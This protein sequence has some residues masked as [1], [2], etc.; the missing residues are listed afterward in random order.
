MLINDFKD[1]FK[2]RESQLIEGERRQNLLIVAVLFF[3]TFFAIAYSLK[4]L[5][6]LKE[7][8]DNPFTN[9]VDLPVMTN[10][11]EDTYSM[12]AGF[13]DSRQLQDSF[14]LS[15]VSAYSKFY[16]RFATAEPE[17]SKEFFGRSVAFDDELL[18]RIVSTDNNV[19]LLVP[20][21]EWNNCGIVVTYRLLES[22]GFDVLD[23]DMKVMIEQS[24]R[25]GLGQSDTSTAAVHNETARF[26]L[27]VYAVVNDLPNYA[28]YVVSP[29]MDNCLRLAYHTTGFINLGDN[30]MN[31]IVGSNVSE[32][33]IQS[34]IGD[35]LFGGIKEVEDKVDRAKGKHLKV[36]LNQPMDESD[37]FSLFQK[38]YKLNSSIKLYYETQC[39]DGFN[40]LEKPSY[41]SFNFKDLNK[42][43]GL[44]NYIKE[45]YKLELDMSLVEDKKNFSKMSQLTKVTTGILFI[46]GLTCISLFTWFFL[47]N[48][49]SQSRKNLGTLSAFGVDTKII[50][51]IYTE[52][53]YRFF[54]KAS[55]LGF[56]SICLTIFL[57]KVFTGAYV[58]NVLDVRFVLVYTFTVLLNIVISKRS[59]TRILDNT[60]GNLIYGRIK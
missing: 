14:G 35:S 60:P 37:K 51:K 27:P 29:M 10:A 49:L 17:K 6:E 52:I 55:L 31:L 5:D 18:N 50:I 28:D 53:M 56:A 24:I 19:K 22:L 39:V 44:K 45:K 1:I 2:T 34:S 23:K 58:A 11:K 48:H 20:R 15:A 54:I 43:E 7:R 32:N 12:L 33:Q 26:Y 36:F 40:E 13:R 30:S 4:G 21:T 8:L 57:A 9:W 42:V 16:T 41:I 46:I 47:R 3:V 38:I 59:I 25:Y